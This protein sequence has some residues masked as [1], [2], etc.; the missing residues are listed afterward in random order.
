MK[1]GW[2]V[3]GVWREGEGGGIGME[4]V[5]KLDVWV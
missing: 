1:G 4:G 2:K 3:D 5:W